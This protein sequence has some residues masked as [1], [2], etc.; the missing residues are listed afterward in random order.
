MSKLTKLNNVA[1]GIPKIL[2]KIIVKI[3]RPI[4]NEK[5]EPI[6]FIIDNMMAPINELANNFSKNFR[7]TINNIPNINNIHIP[8]K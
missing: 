2:T 5:Y 8:A 1:P 7:G 6:K 4:W 3:F